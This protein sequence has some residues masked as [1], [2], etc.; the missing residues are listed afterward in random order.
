[1]QGYGVETKE[2]LKMSY[3]RRVVETIINGLQDPLNQDNQTGGL[4]LHGGLASA[5]PRQVQGV[6]RP[7]PASTAQAPNHRPG[8][9]TFYFDLLFDYPFGGV[10]V[11]NMQS[12]M[13]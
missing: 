12:T 7:H 4:R 13:D 1:M 3:P 11:E 9:F 5:L 2:L 10:E 8:T 6:A